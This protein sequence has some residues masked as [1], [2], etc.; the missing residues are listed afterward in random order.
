MEPPADTGSDSDSDSQSSLKAPDRPNQQ[1][2][3][4]SPDTLTLHEAPEKG[5]S[6]TPTI[7][8]E[9]ATLLHAPA[10]ENGVTATINPKITTILEAPGKENGIPANFGLSIASTD[11]VSS[12]EGTSTK[13]IPHPYTT[14]KSIIKLASR[15]PSATVITAI[16]VLLKASPAIQG[17]TTAPVTAVT[18]RESSA[19]GVRA[20]SSRPAA[21]TFTSDRVLQTTEQS[22][23]KLQSTRTSFHLTRSSTMTAQSA[24]SSESNI[25]DL[26]SHWEE[27]SSTTFSQ[28][29]ITVTQDDVHSF[30]TEP[31]PITLSQPTLSSSQ[32]DSYSHWKEIM[33]T[34]LSRS[35]LT[36]TQDDAMTAPRLGLTSPQVSSS[37]RLE[38]LV[39]TGLS[40]VT[41]P[42]T[43]DDVSSHWKISTPMS[44]PQVTSHTTSTAGSSSSSSIL[45][46]P[47][48]SLP[49]PRHK[50]RPLTPEPKRYHWWKSI[51]YCR[52]D[53]DDCCPGGKLYTVKGKKFND[54]RL[55]CKNH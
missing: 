3:T 34:T 43:Q 28:T 33:P 26:Y 41:L 13:V 22:S 21:D 15:K 2:A 32:I 48:T 36:A 45:P 42:Y 39:P 16:S 49:P 6:A 9:T 25:D 27:I 29:T 12:L 19:N 51:N 40:H 52:P 47:I 38:D 23:A 14:A 1:P 46:R 53:K 24:S 17:T 31:I 5:E 30:S 20:T 11:P 44:L 4:D 54:D 55:I 50:F 37:T 18:I 35:T 7:S 8:Q 10:G